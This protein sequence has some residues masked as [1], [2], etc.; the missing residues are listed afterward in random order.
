MNRRTVGTAAQWSTRGF[1]FVSG[2]IIAAWAPIVPWVKE[3]LQIE[4]S[5][6][7][8][9]LLCLGGGAL[10]MMTFT[11]ALIERFGC[12]CVLTIAGIMSAVSLVGLPLASTAW[13][14]ALLLF[15]FGASMGL[16]DVGSNIHA[17]IVQKHAKRPMMSGFHGL[18]SLGGIA[19]SGCM[20]V[21]LHAGIHPIYA[22]MSVAGVIIAISLVA[23]PAL[24]RHIGTSDKKN[25]RFLPCPKGIVILIGGL[26]FICFL[27]EGA[28]LDWGALYLVAEKGVAQNAS[29]FGYTLFAITVTIGRLIGNRCLTIFGGKRVFLYGSLFALC[30]LLLVL[31]LPTT[32]SSF[33]G[34]GIMGLG[35]ANTI[36]LLVAAAGKQK[37]MPITDAVATVTTVGYTGVLLGPVVLGYIAEWNGYSMAFAFIF[38]LLLFLP[39]G[40]FKIFRG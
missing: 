25:N 6:W 10:C 13:C 29:G 37:R 12:R 19:G 7:G 34:I 27:S 2:T 3:H 20:S 14:L 22:V 32:W 15:C 1:F 39:F 18:Y 17:V 8:T 28:L 40:A 33:I 9:L 5:L 21:L 4:A 30:G 36:P 24:M 16:L 38:L 26:T 11:A 31:A 35:L 23:S